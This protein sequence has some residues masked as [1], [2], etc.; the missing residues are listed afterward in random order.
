MRNTLLLAL[1]ASLL[2]TSACKKTSTNPSG[3]NGYGTFTL[4]DSTYTVYSYKYVSNEVNINSGSANGLSIGFVSPNI[5]PVPGT[6][7]IGSS[8][9]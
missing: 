1:L 9:G 6:Y 3:T 5:P 8:N 4:G 7:S 2:I